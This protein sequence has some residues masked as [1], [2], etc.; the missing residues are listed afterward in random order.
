ML[1]SEFIKMYCENSNITEA[2]LLELKQ[3]A[4]PCYCKDEDCLWRQMVT[5]KKDSLAVVYD[6]EIWPLIKSPP[7]GREIIDWLTTYG[8][9][10]E[11]DTIWSR[12]EIS[13]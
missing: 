10:H 11:I 2:R 9:H 7:K 8:T 6:W 3:Y 13:K 1:Q 4:L 5:I 12:T